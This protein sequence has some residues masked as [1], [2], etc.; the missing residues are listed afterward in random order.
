MIPQVRPIRLLVDDWFVTTALPRSL[1]WLQASDSGRAPWRALIDIAA[2]A[3]EL[4]LGYAD[5][6]RSLIAF[7]MP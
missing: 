6:L 7:A 2:D 1:R 4:A 3:A 5:E